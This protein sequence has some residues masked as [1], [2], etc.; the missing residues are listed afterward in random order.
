MSKKALADAIDGYF[1]SISRTIELKGPDGAVICNDDGEAI[2]KLQFAV[3]PSVSG[4]C[5]H[6]GIDRSTWQN[7]CDGGLHPEFREVT[8][9][10]RG[11]IEAWLEEQLL[12]REKGVQGIIFNLQNN[13]G[14]RQKQEVELG[15]KTRESIQPEGM[16]LQD[17]L[18]AIA[19]AREN[20]GE[21]PACQ[22]DGE[23]E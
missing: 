2:R 4:L 1:R 17:K 21:L 16:S 11:R 14:W 19:Q 23:E 12:M 8:A 7:Y 9:L 20:L 3:P 15:D 18:A 5:L 6:L 10:T 22:G 13:Y